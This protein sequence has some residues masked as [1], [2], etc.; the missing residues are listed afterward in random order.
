MKE[1]WYLMGLEHR[2]L[3]KKKITWISTGVLLVAIVL[4]GIVQIMMPQYWENEENC[5]R[6]EWYQRKRAAVSRLTGRLVDDGFIAEVQ[7]AVREWGTLYIEGE[8]EYNMATYFEVEAPYI[9]FM[10]E[11]VG[12]GLYASDLNSYNRF[13]EGMD[14][15]IRTYYGNFGTNAENLSEGELEELVQMSHDHQPFIYGWFEAYNMYSRSRMTWGI[16]TCMVV[17]ICLAGMFAGESAVRMDALMFSCRFGR[18]KIIPAKILTGLCFAVGMTVFMELVSFLCY[19]LIYGFEGDFLPAQWELSFAVQNLTMGG[20]CL[21]ES[22]VGILASLLTAVITMA[23]SAKSKGSNGVLIL[24]F[25]FLILPNMI[26][27]PA[28]W[29]LLNAVTELMPSAVSSPYGVIS[30]FVLHLG[31]HYFW[32]WQYII[33][34]YL[35]LGM[36][37]SMLAYRTF[38]RRQVGR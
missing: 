19:G 36:L 18:N 24:M 21:I 7:D 3:W 4:L 29:R 30:R 17:A 15:S 11:A 20:L 13:Y 38:R 10:E 5:S 22:L 1:I 25:L 16:F 31:D 23:L 28:E 2:K 8:P 33:P 32:S 26:S 9:V 6:Y 34:V 12:V 14:D 27:F 37:F 35:F